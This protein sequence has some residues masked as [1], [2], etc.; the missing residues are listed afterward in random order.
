MDAILGG[1]RGKEQKSPKRGV[2][3]AGYAPQVQH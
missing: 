2:S 1:K 3:P